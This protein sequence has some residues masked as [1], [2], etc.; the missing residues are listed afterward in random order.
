MPG[1]RCASKLS[2]RLRPK[3]IGWPSASAAF[4]ASRR[5]GTCA[6]SSTKKALASSK[7]SSRG[8]VVHDVL[9]ERPGLFGARAVLLERLD[10][11]ADH[12]PAVLELR[13]VGRVHLVGD[14]ARHVVDEE[15]AHVVGVVLTVLLDQVLVGARHRVRHTAA[16][17]AL[18]LDGRHVLAQVH[19]LGQRG[20][21]HA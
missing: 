4:H 6:T 19:A 5:V 11:G 21:A 12:G 20:R 13:L 10:G 15:P 14:R 18:V 3:M 7:A 9:I 17:G 8:G 1:R 2:Y 16:G